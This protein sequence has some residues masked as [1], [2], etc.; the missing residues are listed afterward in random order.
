MKYYLKDLQWR[1]YAKYSEKYDIYV[2]TDVFLMV[3][4]YIQSM[5]EKVDEISELKVKKVQY[6]DYYKK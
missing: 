2:T 3:S 5:L 4:Q 1:Q 6:E